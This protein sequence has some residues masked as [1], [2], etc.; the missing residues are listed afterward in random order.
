M[1]ASAPDAVADAPD[2]D[3]AF[4]ARLMD[5]VRWRRDVRRF[6]REPVVDAV[7]AELLEAIRLAPSVGLSEPWRIVAVES[8]AARAGVRASF[9]Q[10]N[11]AALAGYEGERARRYAGLKL[12]GLD[13]AP[14]QWALFA[15]MAPMKGHGLGRATMPEMAAYSVACAVMQAWLVARAKGLGIGWVSILEPADVT[16]LL[17][18]PPHWRLVSYLCLGWPAHE[19]DQPELDRAGWETRDAHLPVVIT[20]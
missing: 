18:V 10:A 4:R 15:D 14:V 16:R 12:A 8:L 17:D 6:R 7:L 20:R 2:F 11:N 13:D 3:G 1:S 5:L 19:D 9:A